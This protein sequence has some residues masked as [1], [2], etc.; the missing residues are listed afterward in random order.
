[1]N[2][3]EKNILAFAEQLTPI[4]LTTHHLEKLAPAR[5]D[6]IIIYGMG[7]SG[8]AGE[9]IVA[10][11]NELKLNIPV[12][13]VKDYGL[14]VHDFHRP[15]HI[16]ISFSGNTEETL[17]GLKHLPKNAARAVVTTGGKLLD[18]A[19]REKLPAVTFEAGLL[20]PRQSVGRMF[21]AL[22]ELLHAARLVPRTAAYPH[23][24]PRAFAAASRRLAS[25][26]KDR[27]IFIYTDNAHRPLGYIWKIKFNETSKVQASNNVLPEMD[28]NELT[29]F[30]RPPKAPRVPAAALFLSDH[31]LSPRLKKK[32]AIT[33]RLMKQRGVRVIELPLVGR[34]F[35]EQ[36][37]R[38]LLL[39]DWTSYYLGKLYGIPEGEF[40]IVNPKIV[41][42]LKRLMG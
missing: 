4:G 21:Y 41:I 23:L 18:I 27:L 36:A 37:W 42:D 15:F 30:D 16:F 35:L 31:S 11:A 5:P 34:S 40:N 9:L 29:A 2:H 19:R 6:G 26:L 22:I 39:A 33:A 24:K 3:Y 32:F 17:S 1:M 14:P 20:T 12:R 13:L 28:H 25:Q 8:L 10:A 38:T 7:G